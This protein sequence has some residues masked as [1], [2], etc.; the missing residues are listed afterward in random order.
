MNFHMESKGFN[1]NK[2]FAFLEQVSTDLDSMANENYESLKVSSFNE[3]TVNWKTQVL[4][5]PFKPDVPISGFAPGM[6]IFLSAKRPLLIKVQPSHGEAK[7]IFSFMFKY[8][9]DL[10]QDN[11]VIQLFK[12]M[13]RIWQDGDIKLDMVTY[14]V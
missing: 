8:G 2:L 5:V 13:D 9:D 14:D 6:K 10:R 11:L 4:Y 12:I 3:R 1:E 7:D